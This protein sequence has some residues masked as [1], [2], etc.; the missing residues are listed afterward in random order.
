M[1]D[2]S[3][4]IM[5]DQKIEEIKKIL[6]RW[7]P[8]GDRAV[9]V[10]DLNDYEIEAIDIISSVAMYRDGVKRSVKTVLEQAFNLSLDENELNEYSTEIEKI[11][12]SC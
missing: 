3:V 4:N 11:I 10:E 9:E 5:D 7:N 2:F 6:K 1:F 8:L 12:K